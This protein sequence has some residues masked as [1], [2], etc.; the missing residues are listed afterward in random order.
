MCYCQTLFLGDLGGNRGLHLLLRYCSSKQA[1]GLRTAHLAL[2]NVGSA[3]NE[4]GK[5]EKNKKRLF[6]VRFYVPACLVVTYTV[7]CGTQ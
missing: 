4:K 5:N 6:Y 1:R 7:V 3:G 2:G